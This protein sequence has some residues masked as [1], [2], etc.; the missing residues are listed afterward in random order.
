M[1]GPTLILTPV[2]IITVA[3]LDQKFRLLHN[4][5]T[6]TGV[7]DFG[8]T[9]PAGLVV[10]PVAAVQH[11]RQS[12]TPRSSEEQVP[13]ANTAKD[14]KHG[15]TEAPGTCYH[16]K[17]LLH[18]PQASLP[19][20]SHQCHLC[21]GASGTPVEWIVLPEHSEFEMA[22][23]P[24]L[25]P[26]TAKALLGYTSSCGLLEKS[27]T[28]NFQAP[29]AKTNWLWARNLKPPSKRSAAKLQRRLATASTQ[30]LFS[31]TRSKDMKTFKRHMYMFNTIFSSNGGLWVSA[32][33]QWVPDALTYALSNFTA[34]TKSMIPTQESA[35]S[36]R[37]SKEVCIP[38]D[39]AKT[40]MKDPW[41]QQTTAFWACDTSLPI[42]SSS[43][44][45]RGG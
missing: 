26:A 8:G 2:L 22:P 29:A 43:A 44:L 3:L 25:A 45:A 11:S 13:R 17:H 23:P 33:H 18:R 7:F 9:S 37:A 16:T 6:H 36:T 28:A 41:T 40:V 19:A 42:R 30:K 4:L 5:H 1:L 39:L 27:H 21:V 12:P 35:E 20:K 31:W 14:A 10:A 32:D 38:Q 24:A 15:T 34:L